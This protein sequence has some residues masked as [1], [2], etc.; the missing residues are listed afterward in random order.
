MTVCVTYPLIYCQSL[1]LTQMDGKCRSDCVILSRYFSLSSIFCCWDSNNTKIRLH[2]EKTEIYHE[3]CRETFYTLLTEWLL[4][5]W[6]EI[7][8][9][10][11]SNDTMMDSG[12]S[13]NLIVP[14]NNSQHPNQLSASQPHCLSYQVM[15][16]ER[17]KLYVNN[18]LCC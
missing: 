9:E 14:N 5:S 11:N 2:V 15:D 1:K 12:H 6:E 18:S 16:G 3:S 13:L 4:L 8:E 7:N 10:G 17:C